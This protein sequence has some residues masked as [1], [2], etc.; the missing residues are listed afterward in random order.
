[1][2]RFWITLDQGVSFVLSSLAMMNGGEVFIPKIPSMLIRDMAEALAPGH[3]THVVGI[4]PGEKLH[5]IMVPTDDAR[6]TIELPDRF[7]IQPTFNWWSGEAYRHQGA[8]PVHED[9]TYSSDK[10]GE[11]LN[12]QSL[13]RLLDRL[14]PVA[15]E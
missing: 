5:E 3:P 9:F 4:R 14:E 2:T 7:I 12:G 1:M 13:M 10:N 11:W 8:T 15:A 6:S